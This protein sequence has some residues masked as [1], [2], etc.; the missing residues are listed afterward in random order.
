[1]QNADIIDT[2]RSTEDHVK[3]KKKLKRRKRR[4]LEK[5]REGSPPKGTSKSRSPNDKQRMVIQNGK[6]VA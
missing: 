3:G 6:I 2:M 4:S 1:M 5:K